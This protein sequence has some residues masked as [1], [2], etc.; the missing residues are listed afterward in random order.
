LSPVCIPNETPKTLG[1]TQR[2][3]KEILIRTDKKLLYTWN[4]KWHLKKP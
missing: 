1:E 2:N 3:P 4:P